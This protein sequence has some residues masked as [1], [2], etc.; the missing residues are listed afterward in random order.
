MD[1]SSGA[2]VSGLVEVVAGIDAMTI[3][4]SPCGEMPTGTIG[5]VQNLPKCNESTGK[6]TYT[7]GTIAL[8]AMSIEVAYGKTTLDCLTP[9]GLAVDIW[10]A[11]EDIEICQEVD[12]KF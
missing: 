3:S 9:G 6:W 7:D 1:K 12:L 8:G 10:N 2:T 4:T 11:T 5:G